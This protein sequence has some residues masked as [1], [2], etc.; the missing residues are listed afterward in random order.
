MNTQE[1][2]QIVLNLCSR[3]G[4]KVEKVVEPDITPN[5]WVC[6]ILYKN[7]NLFVLCSTEEKWALSSS[8]EPNIWSLN[9]IDVEEISK[10]LEADYQVVIL[11]SEKLNG[12]FVPT[13]TMCESDIKYWKPETLGQGL[14]NWWD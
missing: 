2:K 5:F 13:S 7:S 9:F 14:F 8:F 4:A 3:I 11:S 1:F 10:V 12:E 6:G